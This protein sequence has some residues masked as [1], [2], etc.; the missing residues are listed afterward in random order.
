M[1]HPRI[2]SQAEMP[3]TRPD[4]PF[5]TA[6]VRADDP[7]VRAWNARPVR[8][9]GDH[10]VYW[11]QATRRADDNVA[12]EHAVARANELGL[13]VVVYEAL[14]ADYPY[15]SDRLHTFVLEC[16]RDSA[17][18]LARRGI[19]HGFFLPTTAEQ[20]RGVAGRVFARA[21]LV[22]SDDHPSFLHPAQ[23]AA[24]AARAPCAYVTV[25][26]AAVVPLSTIVAHEP[27][28]RTIRPKLLRAL[29]EWLQPVKAIAPKIAPAKVDWP[30][31]PIDLA[32]ADLAALVAE[33][34]IDH[35]V[36][37]VDDRRGGAREARRRL[38]AFLRAA[39]K[40]YDVGRD[41]VP[42]DGT[43]GLSAYLHFGAISAR[44][45]LL[46]A[47]DA[48]LPA[49]AHEAFVEQ[50]LVR[51]GLAFNHAA[52]SPEHARWQGVPEWARRT[53]ESHRSDPRPDAR[54]L[55]AL[56]RAASGDPIWDAAQRD[57]LTRGRMHN[58][59]R[60]YWGKSLL[61]KIADPA[62]AFAFGARMFDRYALDGRDPN[63]YTGVGWCFGLH[64]R[65]FPERPIFG[66]VR[67]MGAG[68]LKRR[69]DLREWLRVREK[70]TDVASQPSLFGD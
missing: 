45:C 49:A 13:P 52:R 33:C 69:F 18:A 19:P 11:C 59:L 44:A 14:R 35:S 31:T 3:T 10:V 54:P 67:P 21:A 56:E 41:E 46:A 62:E 63:T 37:P 39:G 70:D 23:N 9:D 25:D 27:Q 7:R 38:T 66:T 64:D 12:L 28:A 47:R 61:T 6:N 55:D 53:L 57:L 60:M 5:T 36:R 2:G 65:P 58:V 4:P 50:L 40:R 1:V 29:D 26:D 32:Q 8:K 15:A 17:A 48:G 68:A 22:V 30:F 34:A 43:S 16:A 42:S 20:A 51:R 24:A